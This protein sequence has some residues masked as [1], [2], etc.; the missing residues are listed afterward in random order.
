MKLFM[1][2]YL[3]TILI[4][5]SIISCISSDILS[6]L[7]SGRIIN[8]QFTE[9]IPFDYS[10]GI[11]I[12]KARINE[13]SKNYRFIL[14]SG[15]GSC[16]ISKQIFQDNN[17][18]VLAKGHISSGRQK[19]VV[20]YTELDTL[21]LGTI[22]FNEIPAAVM[23]LNTSPIFKCIGVDGIIGNRCLHLIPYCKID[24]KNLRLTLSDSPSIIPKS[25]NTKKVL[26]ILKNGYYPVVK[27]EFS[28]SLH[29]E[30]II[31]L[32]FSSSSGMDMGININEC[33][34]FKN[35]YENLNFIKGNGYIRTDA[36][37]Q[38]SGNIICI[39]TPNILLG[40]LALPYTFI[41]FQDDYTI[42]NIGNGFFEDYILSIDWNKNQL[43]L[44]P[45]SDKK[46]STS[47]SGHGLTFIYVEKDSSLIIGLIYD[48]SAAQKAGLQV[49]DRI[50]EINKQR[51]DTIDLS[52]YC[53]LVLNRFYLNEDIL[54]LKVQRDKII[55]FI[56]KKECLI[57]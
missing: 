51:T 31:D 1:K 52:Q 9:I 28:P 18:E 57:K 43:F 35:I 4:C 45:Y 8:S 47:F 34:N 12:V 24:Y 42:A 32:G 22:V 21:H 10:M 44:T 46:S 25:E 40:E 33:S 26:F 30:F 5:L 15:A 19:E 20:N 6:L 14:D 13:G 54:E 53:N 49:G 39:K 11:I 29:R 38:V 50:I 56:I 17:L 48:D 41:S 37:G 7:K 23:D 36:L 27:V 2:K 55:T 3:C 16:I